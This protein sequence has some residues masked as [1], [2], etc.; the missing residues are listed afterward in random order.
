MADPS[1]RAALVRSFDDQLPQIIF[2]LMYTTGY[3]LMLFGIMAGIFV[4][5][6]RQSLFS[7]VIGVLTAAQ[8]QVLNYFFG[9]VLGRSHK[10]AD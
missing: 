6:E 8:G 9:S 2:G 3:F 1:F 4:L 5:P 10:Q 7:A